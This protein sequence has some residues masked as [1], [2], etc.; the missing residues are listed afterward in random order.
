MKKYVLDLK[1]VRCGHLGDRY[2][3]LR[4]TA[5]EELPEMLPGQFAELR[6]DGSPDTFLRRPISIHYVDRALNEVWFLVA[7]V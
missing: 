5:D 1:V 7:M 4:L 2:A 6:V 3:I